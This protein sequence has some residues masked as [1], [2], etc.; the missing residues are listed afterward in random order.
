MTEKL[1][2]VFYKMNK[3]KA[4]AI[5]TLFVVNILAVML[6]VVLNLLQ[7]DNLF[8]LNFL[9]LL[10]PVLLLFL[11]ACWT[12]TLLRGMAFILLAGLAGFLFERI[13]LE[14]ASFF[15]GAYHYGPTEIGY[16][17]LEVPLFV[18]LFWAVYIYVGY[19]LTSSFLSWN[20]L[21]KP[22]RGHRNTLWLFFLL[23]MDIS[24]VV[25]IDLIMDPLLVYAGFWTWEE[26]GSFFGV[27]AGNFGGWAVVTFLVS[28]SFRLWEYF[29]PQ[30]KTGFPTSTQ[31]IP[32]LGYAA[33]AITFS[34]C[35]ISIEYYC[36]ALIGFFTMM[37][38]A[39]VNLM[40]YFRWKK[41]N[42]SIA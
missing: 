1:V 35:A 16:T 11:H 41:R 28:G 7:F 31:L 39:T 22:S 13:G 26:N 19:S 3:R 15:G 6:D 29:F 40:F 4:T 14:S 34:L 12:L 23:L 21:Q 27:P 9:T 10:F 37:P 24:A 8:Y 42:H 5:W 18:P 36:L 38:F 20:L 17:I 33:L 25:A 2:S 30:Q 32:V